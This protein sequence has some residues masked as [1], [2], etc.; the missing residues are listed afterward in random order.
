M[1]KQ[2]QNTFKRVWKPIRVEIVEQKVIPM[3]TPSLLALMD[4]IITE[5]SV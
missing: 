5:S 1:L 4:G 2:L 3:S